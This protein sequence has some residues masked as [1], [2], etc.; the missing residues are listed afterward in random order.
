MRR[1]QDGFGLLEA[2]LALAIGLMLL[3]AFSQLFISA[4]QSWRLQG[5]A[6]RLQMDARLALT[7]M[8]QD[9]RMAGT[10]GCLRLEPGDFKDPTARQVFS[11]PL[12][13]AHASLSLVVGDLPGHAGE[14]DWTLLTDC[15]REAEVHSGRV[16]NAGNALAF[17]VSRHVYQ[18]QGTSLIFKRRG[19]S[20]TLV[21]DVREMRVETVGGDRVDIRL[22]LFDPALDIEQRYDLSVAIRNPVAQP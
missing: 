2:M 8:A 10:F 17:P 16:Q 15:L 1:G 19:T 18:L 4:H 20:R 11:Q 6:A 7:G 3:T 13:V 12:Q 5:A 14:P 22:T 9:I 21:D